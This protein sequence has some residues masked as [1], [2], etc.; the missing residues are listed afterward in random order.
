MCVH[1]APYDLA[2]LAVQPAEPF[3]D[4]LERQASHENSEHGRGENQPGVVVVT[5]QR[6]RA[7]QDRSRATGKNAHACQGE[8]RFVREAVSVFHT[9]RKGERESHD[10]TYREPSE[11]GRPRAKVGLG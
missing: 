8:E 9:Q 5:H 10:A 11:P 6:Q 1:L 4:L 2:L 7:G 3:S